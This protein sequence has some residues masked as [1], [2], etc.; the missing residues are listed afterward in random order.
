VGKGAIV[1]DCREIIKME[2][3][4][5]V[6]II[7][8]SVSMNVEEV[9]TVVERERLERNVRRRKEERKEEK[10]RKR[11][12]GEKGKWIRRGL[13]KLIVGQNIRGR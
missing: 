7:D 8:C 3:M 5:N 1:K 11:M 12:G 13:S 6:V 4:C 9:G 10:R 2:V